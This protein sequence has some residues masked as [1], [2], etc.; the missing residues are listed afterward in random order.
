LG[1]TGSSRLREH[2]DFEYGLG[3]TTTT[4]LGTRCLLHTNTSMGMF[5]VGHIFTKMIKV[6]P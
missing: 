4:G 6:F 5:I 3:T 2:G 1:S